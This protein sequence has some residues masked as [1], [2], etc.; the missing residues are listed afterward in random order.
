MTRADILSWKEKLASGADLLDL[1]KPS[2]AEPPSTTPSKPPPLALPPMKATVQANSQKPPPAAIA[3]AIHLSDPKKTIHPG[4]KSHPTKKLI[5]KSTFPLKKKCLCL[6]KIH[7]PSTP[8]DSALDFLNDT[9]KPS[10]GG[11]ELDDFLSDLDI[12]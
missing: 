8:G 2:I 7:Q 5:E 11:S 6:K 1:E 10:A 3:P 12:D 9:N 4:N